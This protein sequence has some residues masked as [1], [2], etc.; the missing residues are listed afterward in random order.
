MKEFKFK[1]VLIIVLIILIVASII[2]LPKI[3]N[4]NKS[5]F[6][7]Q[8]IEVK[9]IYKANEIIPL[10][11]NDEQMA[12]I[13]LRDYI[14][15]LINDMN[16]SYDLLDKNYRDERFGNINDYKSFIDSLKISYDSQVK[17]FAVYTSSIYK[18]YDVYDQDNNRFIFKTNGVMQYNVYFDDIDEGEEE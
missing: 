17:R 10:Y 6:D 8:K 1:D 18:F 15:N 12:K 14:N 2:Y 7:Y 13:Y 9:E 4:K 16:G 11:V 5:D 3:L